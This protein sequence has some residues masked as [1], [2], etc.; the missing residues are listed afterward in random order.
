MKALTASMLTLGMAATAGVSTTNVLGE[1][2]Q[3]ATGVTRPN[4]PASPSP[5]PVEVPRI[6][7]GPTCGPATPACRAPVCI[8]P[9]QRTAQATAEQ[10][11]AELYLAAAALADDIDFDLYGTCD[12]AHLMR[13]AEIIVRDAIT[14]RRA[15]ARPVRLDG[16]MND[17]R[18]AETRL[19]HLERSIGRRYRTRAIHF[20]LLDVE[21]A[22]NELMTGLGSE[23][24]GQESP[25]SDRL[26]RRTDLQREEL[27][28]APT[29]PEPTSPSVPPAFR[30]GPELE[31]TDVEPL[32]VPA[33]GGALV[34]PDS[35]K[36][37]RQLSPSDQRLAI[38][39]RTCPVTG[40]LLG[41][42][43]KP[44]RVRV[45][46]RSVFVC[47]QGCVDEVRMSS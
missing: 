12:F 25:R 16:V 42:M 21:M 8:Q 17:V 41:S 35:M 39:Q 38:Q 29:V 5:P 30:P 40:D 34:I 3:P 32:V 15:L 37:I 28:S 46:G 47:C 27:Q 14:I 4:P 9:V 26:S 22:L 7:P 2:G 33:P 23:T 31:S 6:S 19:R 10:L 24:V 44:I 43:G 45:N 18:K 11:A 36:G 1:H 20:S 13:D